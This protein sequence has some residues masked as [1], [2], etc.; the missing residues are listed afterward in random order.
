[1]KKIFL[2]IYLNGFLDELEVELNSQNEK[3]VLKLMQKLI[4]E[5]EKSLNK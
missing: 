4:P 5:W 1:M 2:Q 3:Q